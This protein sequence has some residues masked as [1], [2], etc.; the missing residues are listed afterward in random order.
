MVAMAMTARGHLRTRTLAPHPVPSWWTTL[1]LP[2]VRPLAFIAASCVL[3]LLSAVVCR[4]PW[5]L[6]FVWPAG[7]VESMRAFLEE[8]LP[9]AGQVVAKAQRL[10]TQSALPQESRVDIL[11]QALFEPATVMTS[12][13]DEDTVAPLVALV[14]GSTKL[15]VQVIRAAMR[16]AAQT[17]AL[18]K[19][20][21]LVL[22][23]LYDNDVLTDE[24]VAAWAADDAPTEGVVGDVEA[25]FRAK[26]GPFVT[27]VAEAD[28]ESDDSSDDDDA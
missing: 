13:G 2:W 20:A 7:A 23:N 9:T 10:Q 24:S 8:G 5:R 16:Q 12:S 14:E 4:S 21:P 6:P 19:A 25:A 1:R 22:K 17:P 28:E 15:Q 11:F 26:A 3:L 18:I 27:W